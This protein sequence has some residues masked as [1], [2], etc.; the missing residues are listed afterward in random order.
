MFCVE[1]GKEDN[2]FKNGV[3]IDCYLKNNSFTKGPEIID[4]FICSKCFS[5]KYKNTWLKDSFEEV[6]KR[7]IKNKFQIS[8]ELKKVQ[9]KTTCDEKDKNVLCEVFISGLV[10]GHEILEK[11]LI[12]VRKKGVVC[13]ICSKQF[14]GYFEATFQ[15][16]ADKRKLKK[17]EIGII[18]SD[19][20]NLVKSFR[21]KGNRG[22]FIT[23]FGEEHGGIDFYLSEKGCAYT[24]AKKIQDKFG[25]EIVESSKNFGMK[26]GRQLYRMTYLLRLPVYKKG[27]FILFDGSYFYV[28]SISGNKVHIIELSSW[29]DK[30]VFDGKDLRNVLVLGREDLV[31]EMILVSQSKDEVQVM[32]PVSYKTFELRKPRMVSFKSKMVKTVKFEDVVF[33]LSDKIK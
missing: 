9:I 12:T 15:V 19:V 7:H 32:D 11:H 29:M 20:E 6:L 23:D 27:D 2:I 26:D 33:L 28:S 13:D 14:G 3:C 31:K 30:V 4:I 21:N 17:E 5:Y 8:N 10:D 22:L 16:R 25:G 1:C 18:S 24:I